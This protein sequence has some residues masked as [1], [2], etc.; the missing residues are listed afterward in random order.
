M[1]GGLAHDP[2]VHFGYLDEAE[3]QRKYVFYNKIDPGNQVE[4]EYR[5]IIGE[6][7]VHAPGPVELVAYKDE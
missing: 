3:R 1:C 7:D 5:H 6:P 2:V 4:G